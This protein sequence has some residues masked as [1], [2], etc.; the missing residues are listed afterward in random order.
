MARPAQR[1]SAQPTNHRLRTGAAALSITFAG[2][3]SLSACGS[4][5]SSTTTTATAT[6]SASL[7]QLRPQAHRL[8]HPRQLPLPLLQT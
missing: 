8:K 5:S 4:Q 3:L 7:R 2:A 1:T 6:A